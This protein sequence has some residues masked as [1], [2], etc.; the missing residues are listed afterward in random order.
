MWRAL[1]GAGYVEGQ[2]VSDTP[3]S[4]LISRFES[5]FFLDTQRRAREAAGRS[6]EAL[7]YGKRFLRSGKPDTD[8]VASDDIIG[9]LIFGEPRSISRPTATNAD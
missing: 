5:T 6:F 2:D 1:T 4:S 3:R 8:E 7:R 9:R